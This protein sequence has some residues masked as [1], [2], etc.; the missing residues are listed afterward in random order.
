MFQHIFITPSSGQTSWNLLRGTDDVTEVTEEYLL[1]RTQVADN[2]GHLIPG[3]CHTL[4]HT[5]EAQVDTVIGARAD[6]DKT[7]EPLE[8][9]HYPIDTSVA[10]RQPRIARVTS[11]SD[12]CT[13]LLQG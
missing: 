4:C 9:S 10:G 5:T 6:L 12:F 3:I 13:R 8:S 7:L 1:P 11:H 2:I